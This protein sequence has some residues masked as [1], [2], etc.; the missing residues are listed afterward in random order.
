[1]DFV[2][3]GITTIAA[4]ED[5]IIALSVVPDMLIDVVAHGVSSAGSLAHVSEIARR[6]CVLDTITSSSPIMVD[7]N[8][9]RI[10][11]YE[12]PPNILLIY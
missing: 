1:M 7:S 4:I 9:I 11:V 5:T 12:P 2:T 8:S 3:V 6:Q 10:G